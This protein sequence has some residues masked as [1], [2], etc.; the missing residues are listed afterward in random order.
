[1][2]GEVENAPVEGEAVDALTGPAIAVACSRCGE[3]ALLRPG[4]L[5]P[6]CVAAIG[7][8]DDRTEYDEW[9]SRVEAAI[10]AGP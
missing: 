10:T 3:R 9:R 7:L 5:C 4:G 1:M 2:S 6:A 8:S